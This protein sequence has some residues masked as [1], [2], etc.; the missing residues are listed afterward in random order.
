MQLFQKSQL[1]LAVDIGTALVSGLVWREHHASEKPDILGVVRTPLTRDGIRYHLVP[2]LKKFLAQTEFSL[3]GHDPASVTIGLAAPYYQ[4]KTVWTHKT[5]PRTFTVSSALLNT[6]CDEEEKNQIRLLSSGEEFFNNDILSV[7]LNGYPVGAYSEGKEAREISMAMRFSSFR[8]A[9][10]E[11]IIAL[12]E[13]QYPQARVR[14]TTFPVAY[15]RLFQRMP[16]FADHA[17]IIDIGGGVSELSFFN[18]GMLT[19]VITVPHG[20]ETWLASVAQQHNISRSE[21]VSVM[22]HNRFNQAF[23]EHMEEWK[24]LMRPIIAAHILQQPAHHFFLV[25]G[26]SLLAQSSAALS[27]LLQTIRFGNHADVHPLSVMIF[28][29]QFQKW[30]TT[31]TSSLDVGLLTLATDEL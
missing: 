18:D 3:A 26:G 4:G 5:F 15:G 30:S 2:A 31:L 10:R 19:E 25:G 11:Q 1:H 29:D 13:D 12:F 20:L 21:L 17:A 24:Q 23:K 28:R 8:S 6:L 14:I 16:H 7:M 27:S 22:N 9:L